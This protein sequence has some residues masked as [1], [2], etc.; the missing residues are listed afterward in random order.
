MVVDGPCGFFVVV[1]SVTVW[2]SCGLERFSAGDDFV[3]CVFFYVVA[4][5][6]AVSVVREAVAACLAV[7]D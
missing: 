2:A 4:G 7:G 1:G 5:D 3:Y 6:F